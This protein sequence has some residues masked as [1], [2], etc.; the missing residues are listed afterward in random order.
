VQSASQK[1]M[2]TYSESGPV[3]RAVSASA[4]A[5]SA[6]VKSSRQVGAGT[7]DQMTNHAGYFI[8][9][10]LAM[11]GAFPDGVNGSATPTAATVPG[12][13]LVVDY[14]AVYQTGTTPPTTTTTTTTS[15]PPGGGFNAYSEI[16]A[17]NAQER[18]GGTV[19]SVTEGGDGVHQIANG[20]YL[21]FSGVNFGSSTASQ[22]YAR[23]ASGAAG[24]VSGLVEVRLGS[25]TAAPV[26]TFAV[27]NTGGWQSWRTV[28]ANIS[29]IT[30]THDVYITFNSGQPA[31]YVSVNWVKF[32]T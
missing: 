31:P 26:G 4:A 6:A 5:W 2:C 12:H 30:G 21:K 20:G 29:G 27:A 14:V 8:L 11:G 24:G 23:V 10:N 13:S 28:P 1:G 19:G 7:W 16:Q 32:G 25:R 17:E 9:L 15:N 18:A 22:F 3:P